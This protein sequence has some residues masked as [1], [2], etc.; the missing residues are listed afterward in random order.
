MRLVALLGVVVVALVGLVLLLDVVSLSE[1]VDKTKEENE[2]EREWRILPPSP[3][4]PLRVPESSS[5]LPSAQALNKT[6]FE[7]AMVHYAQLHADSLCGLVPPRY[8][9]WICRGHCPGWGDRVRGMMTVMTLGILTNR[10]VLFSIENNDMPLT[11]IYKADPIDWDRKVDEGG[12]I[13]VN[14]LSARKPCTFL[15]RKV[16]RALLDERGIVVNTNGWC[17]DH[18]ASHPN[19]ASERERLGI[20]GTQFWRSILFKT[21]LSPTLKL[22]E[23]LSRYLPKSGPSRAVHIRTGIISSENEP[24][25]PTDKDQHFGNILHCLNQSLSSLPEEAEVP[26]FLA[27]DNEDI[28]PDFRY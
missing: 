21:F 20:E 25:F 26:T 3:D 5:P 18:F 4:D 13:R 6:R 19:F 12:M 1:L 28:I 15:E 22:T 17:W 23:S 9:I 14:G 7:E 2:E 11:D 8:L 27:V 24:R 10:T 16:M